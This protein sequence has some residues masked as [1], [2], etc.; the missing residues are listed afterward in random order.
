MLIQAEVRGKAEAKCERERV[1]IHSLVSVLIG[2][3]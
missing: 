2:M 1:L 3:Q